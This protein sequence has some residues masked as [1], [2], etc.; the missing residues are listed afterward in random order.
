MLR[1]KLLSV[2]VMLTVAV[3]CTQ[4]DTC[5]DF[6]APCYGGNCG[7]QAYA[8]AGPS[9]P[10]YPTGGETMAPMPMPGPAPAPMLAPAPAGAMPPPPASSSAFAP[11]TSA[12]PAS[13]NPPGLPALPPATTETTP[14]APPSL[15]DSG[16]P[17]L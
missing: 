7:P 1:L 11:R 14:P 13:A 10:V 5:D 8:P 17:L 15:G 2:A 6:P 3:G 16:K 4:C 9:V 12:S